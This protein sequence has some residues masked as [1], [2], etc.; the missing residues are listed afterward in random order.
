MG[1]LQGRK[2]KSGKK[3]E[4]REGG[5][6]WRMQVSFGF[7]QRRSVLRVGPEAAGAGWPE[8]GWPE[9]GLSLSLSLT[10]TSNKKNWKQR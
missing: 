10:R 8:S 3:K 9:S 6:E 2:R 1:G 5:K 7:C 4:R